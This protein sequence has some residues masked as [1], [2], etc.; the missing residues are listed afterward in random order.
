MNI[1]AAA[2]LG[3]VGAGGLGQQIHIAVSLFLENQLLTLLLAI[4]L[5]VTLVDYLSACLQPY[6]ATLP[7]THVPWHTLCTSRM[8]APITERQSGKPDGNRDEVVS[9]MS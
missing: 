8:P 4:Y 9:E 7:R 3:L 6:L 2:I 5:V 1:R